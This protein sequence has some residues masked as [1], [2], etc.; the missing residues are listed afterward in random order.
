[1]QVVE[2]PGGQTI[3]LDGAHNPDGAR[4]LAAVLRNHFAHRKPAL[5]L[6]AMSDKDCAAICAVL[7]PLASRILISPVQSQR[8][9]DPQWLA[10][11]CRRANGAA[12]ITIC[13]SLADALAQSAA[14]AFVVVTGSLYL[15]GA[16]MV[17]LGLAASSDEAALN[18]YWP[19]H[20]GPPIRAVTFDVGGTLIA[21][22][23]SVGHVYAQIAGRHGRHVCA[24]DLDRQ[25][26]A[27]WKAKKSFGY[28]MSDW[29]NLVNQSFAGLPGDP[30]DDVLFS[31]LYDHFA[32]PGPWRVFDDVLP[33]LQRLK[34]RG[35]KLAVISNWDERLRPLLRALELEQY[36]DAIIVSAEVGSHKPDAKVFETAANR[37][38]I[39]AGAILHVGDSIAE[40]YEGA[41][42]SEFRAVLL[43]RGQPAAKD[44]I[45]SL[46]L[47][48]C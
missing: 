36:F 21:P 37:L 6:G 47:L 19:S 12:P 42:A 3:I 34:R 18:D 11:L 48:Q 40:D 22:W 13:S 46:D 7:A 30:P 28:S 43:R 35:F 9:A 39:P 26:A 38:G 25:F 41:R 4:S 5:I 1:M 10:D 31:E 44:A 24:E 14:D 15:V 16:A 45:P 29:S 20:S 2:K 8:G 32:T 33:C 27:T 23:P 17:A